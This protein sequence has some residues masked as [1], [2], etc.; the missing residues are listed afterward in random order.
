MKCRSWLRI[1]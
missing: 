1:W